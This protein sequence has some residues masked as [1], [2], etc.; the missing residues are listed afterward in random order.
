MNTRQHS[1]APGTLESVNNAVTSHFHSSPTGGPIEPSWLLMLCGLGNKFAPGKRAGK[2]SEHVDSVTLNTH[3]WPVLFPNPKLIHCTGFPLP[4]QRFCLFWNRKALSG[5]LLLTQSQNFDETASTTF[6]ESS[7]YMPFPLSRSPQRIF[8]HFLNKTHS[9]SDGL[10]GSMLTHPASPSDFAFYPF[11][12]QI[13]YC[14]PITL[15]LPCM[16][17]LMSFVP[18]AVLFPPAQSEVGLSIILAT[19]L[20]PFPSKATKR[21][22][23]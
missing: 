20:L 19:I 4:T 1:H 11:L 18:A 22:P 16:G 9:P 2:K 5:F 15:S 3:S 13:A 23:C 10:W 17:P 12:P 8:N 14:F 6:L 21:Q 7:S